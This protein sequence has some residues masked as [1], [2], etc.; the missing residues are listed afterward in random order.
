MLREDRKAARDSLRAA[1]RVFP[2]YFPGA[3]AGHLS[4]PVHY[5]LEG[6]LLRDVAPGDVIDLDRRVRQGVHIRGAL[7]QFADLFLLLLRDRHRQL[8]LHRLGNPRLRLAE[9]ET[10]PKRAC[11][12]AAQAHRPIRTQLSTPLDEIR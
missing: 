2:L 1:G 10:A 3:W 6:Y 5:W 4:L 12:D 8:R 9:V 7:P 11:P